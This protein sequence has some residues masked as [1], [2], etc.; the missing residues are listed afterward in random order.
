[1]Q[2]II[3]KIKLEFLPTK[4]QNNSSNRLLYIDVLKILAAFL[5]VFYHFAYYEL[6]Y[7]FIEGQAYYPNIN[8]IVM[9]FASCCV[10][11]FFLV[12][13]SLMLKTDRRIKP[14][15]FK[16]A[17]IVLLIALWSW[18]GFPSWF[19]KTLCILYFL[20]PVFKLVIKNK[21]THYITCI[22]VFIFPFL[23]NFIVF[24]IKLWGISEIS[25]FGITLPIGIFTRTGFFT[26]YSILYFLLGPILKNLKNTNII[27]DVSLITLGLFLVVWECV[28]Y[29]NIDN[30]MF[31]GVNAS[32]PTIGALFLSVG[33][34]LLIKKG[35]Y[36]RFSKVLSFL[37]SGALTIYLT[38]SLFIKLFYSIATQQ[39]KISLILSL[40]ASALICLI[41]AF[42]GKIASKIPVVCWFFKI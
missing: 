42:I 10:P 33:L 29:T 3:E 38:H 31:D 20:M 22:A 30:Q 14:L 6:D 40:A 41:A 23:Y 26:L 18:S 5:T 2:N 32:F 28:G 25:A 24:L 21:K 37:G 39:L 11:L 1:M 8:R 36:I 12:N 17:K 9:C 15:Y 7:G 35:S 16:I 34:Y 27:I 4:P 13:G 19:F